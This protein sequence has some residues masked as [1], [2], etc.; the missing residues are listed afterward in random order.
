MNEL[1]LKRKIDDEPNHYAY[2]SIFDIFVLKIKFSDTLKYT[3]TFSTFFNVLLSENK[4]S[5]E[6]VL[7]VVGSISSFIS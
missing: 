4:T 2:E 6:T 3:L 5:K 7:H 1:I